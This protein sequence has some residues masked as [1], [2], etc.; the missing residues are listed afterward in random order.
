MYACKL[1]I[2][3]GLS[4]LM[5]QTANA[6]TL[7]NVEISYG[8]SLS[9][10]A[11]GLPALDPNTI[12]PW[13]FMFISNTGAYPNVGSGSTLT[14]ANFTGFEGLFEGHTTNNG[15]E[16]HNSGECRALSQLEGLTTANP[17][18]QLFAGFG[19]GGSAYA[20]LAKGTTPYSNIF[21]LNS[22]TGSGLAAAVTLAPAGYA[23]NVPGWFWVQGEFDAQAGTPQAT[24]VTD[25]ETIYANFNS[26]AKATTG[27]SNNVPMLLTQETNWTIFQSGQSTGQAIPLAQLQATQATPGMYLVTP[28]YP[29]PNSNLAYGHIQTIGYEHLGE[30]AGRARYRINPTGTNPNG[31]WQ[32]PQAGTPT[33]VSDSV[34]DVP[35][36]GE[37]DGGV[38]GVANPLV[39]DCSWVTS[40]NGA[41]DGFGVQVSGVQK[42]ISSVFIKPDGKTAEI[43]LATALGSGTSTI[44]E[45]ANTI[46]AQGG[47]TPG[48]L[49]GLRGC[50]HDSSTWNSLYDNQALPVYA[51]EFQ[52]A[53]ITAP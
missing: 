37:T 4:L 7:L 16:S 19:V 43:T 35:F 22:S 47:L 48:H 5:V 34:I 46:G 17:G 14:S 25:L 1:L 27:Q 18:F 2:A 3:L 11:E 33:F 52:A 15:G 50:V 28:L 44:V 9:I 32:A 10:G 8:Q 6:T 26:D 51:T 13:C 38:I 24:Y 29:F 49:T 23:V 36:T 20:A 31:N 42:T 41:A 40:P 21:G 53:A 45:Y 30:Y 39:L 12:N